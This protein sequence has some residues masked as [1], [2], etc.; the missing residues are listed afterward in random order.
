MAA[1]NN[2]SPLSGGGDPFVDHPLA[3]E[4]DQLLT[5]STSLPSLR[6]QQPSRAE[7]AV[8]PNSLLPPVHNADAIFP[9]HN[10]NLN[11]E[12][13]IDTTLLPPPPI[14]SERSSLT[15]L[16][17]TDLDLL[18][19]VKESQLALPAST[20]AD[21]PASEWTQGQLGETRKKK[22]RSKLFWIGAG[23]GV[24]IVLSLAVFL[25]VF[26]GV[27]KKSRSTSASASSSSSGG[28]GGGGTTG[29]GTGGGNGGSTNGVIVSADKWPGMLMLMEMII[30]RRRWVDRDD[31]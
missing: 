30:D 16:G 11:T 13:N 22:K 6:A 27:V 20:Y 2:P 25:P 31:G 23:L 12:S 10:P 29:G 8:D 1:Y 9:A 28:G 3:V 21:E 15:V 19:P 5:T 7:D 24:A 17:N 4:G 26:F 18:A 14:L